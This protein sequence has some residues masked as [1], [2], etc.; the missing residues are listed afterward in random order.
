MEPATLQVVN[1]Q[2]VGVLGAFIVA[3]SGVL[4]WATKHMLARLESKLDERTRLWREV[5]AQLTNLRVDLPMNY[6]QREDWIRFAGSIDAKYDAL[7][8]RLDEILG[9]RTR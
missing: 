7:H 4:L 9:Q 5:E 1:W 2:A 6:V 3:W 8:K